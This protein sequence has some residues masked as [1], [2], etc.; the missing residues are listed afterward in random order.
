VDVFLIGWFFQQA[1]WVG[2][3]SVGFRAARPL[4][5]QGEGSA[6]RSGRIGY[7]SYGGPFFFFARADDRSDRGHIISGSRGIFAAEVRLV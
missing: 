7:T 3:L 1:G 2:R 4:K 6:V 5:D